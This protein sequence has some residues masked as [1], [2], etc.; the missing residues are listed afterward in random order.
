MNHSN[1][2]KHFYADLIN[3]MLQHLSV[4]KNERHSEL[5][6]QKN[7]ST[8]LFSDKSCKIESKSKKQNHNIIKLLSFNWY[9]KFDQI[10][11]LKTK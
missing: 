9:A 3:F 1:S 8:E 5:H 10:E 7:H 2:F 6:F 11:F 4:V